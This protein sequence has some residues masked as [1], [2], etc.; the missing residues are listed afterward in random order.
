MRLVGPVLLLLA[1]VGCKRTDLNQPCRLSKS[2]P[3]GGA[4]VQLLE[5]EIRANVGLNKDFIA[6]KSVDCDDVCVR[7]SAFVSDAGPFDPAYGYCSTYCLEGTFCPS[8]DSALDRG[9][10]RLTC[11]ALL[12]DPETLGPNAELF[13]GLREPFFC[14]RGAAPDAGL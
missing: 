3:D 13:G 8:Q 10:T 4:A 1:V 6:L 11:R 12:L 14:A 9:S 5:S 2:S 7:D